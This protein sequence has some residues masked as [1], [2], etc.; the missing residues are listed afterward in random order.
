VKGPTPTISEVTADLL[1]LNIWKKTCLS[2]SSKNFTLY[3]NE[4][5]EL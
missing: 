5:M 1:E 4:F 3:N 2:Y